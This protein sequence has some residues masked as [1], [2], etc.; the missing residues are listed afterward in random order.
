MQWRGAPQDFA[1][2]SFI[3]P[4]GPS[5]Y[6]PYWNGMQPG[7]QSGMDGYMGSYGGGMLYNM[8]YGVGPMG[9]HFPGGVPHDTFMAQNPMY[10]TMPHDPFMAQNPMYPTMPPPR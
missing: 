3:M 10:P 6:N 7:F 1:A 5:S 9:V 2:D 4:T 8:G